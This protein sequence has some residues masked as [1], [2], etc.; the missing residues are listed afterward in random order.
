[1]TTQNK[2]NTSM[3]RLYHFINDSTLVFNNACG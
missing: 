1:M 2:Y 3:I